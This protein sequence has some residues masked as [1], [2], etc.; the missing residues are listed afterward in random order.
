MNVHGYELIGDWEN[1]NCGKIARATKGGKKYFLKKYQT[2]VA[3]IDNGTLDAKTFAHNQRLFDDF[4]NRRTAVNSRIRTISGAG[5]NIIIPCEEFMDGNQLVEASEFVEGVVAKE[6][7][8]AVLAGL[9]MDTKRLLMLTAAGALSSVHSKGIIHSDLKLPNVLLVKNSM[10]N[11][12]AKL[13]DFDS[14][15]PSDNKP[16]EMIGTP[17]YYSP[18]LGR[19]ITSEDYSEENKRTITEKTDIFSLGLIY[20]FYL[21]GGFPEAVSLT[22]KLQRKKDKGKPIYPYVVLNNGCELRISPE[23]TD[24]TYASLITDMLNIDPTKRPTA[25][26]TLMR[27]KMPGGVTRSSSGGSGSGSGVSTGGRSGVSGSGVITGGITRTPP[28][29]FEA[30]WPEHSVE[31]D[32]AK[33]NSAGFI[34]SKNDTLGGVKGY[35]FYK[36]DGREQFMK[37]E[38]LLLLKYAKKVVGGTSGSTGGSGGGVS[39]PP[40]SRSDAGV[41]TPPPP[42]PRAGGFADPW[43]EHKIV[44]DID[45]IKAKG[46]VSTSQ[47]TMGG[48]NGYEFVR[49]N[50]SAQFIRVETITMLKMAKK[51]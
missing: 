19:Y 48:V 6:D 29:G 7:M 28:T 34:S 5:G 12:V 10:G 43:P 21:T 41:S 24:P 32:T 25:S 44:F 16:D 20:H 14:S 26:E 11:Y 4:F 1:S 46:Y 13:V 50:G 36:A 15:Y 42:P 39:T 37:V 31:F 49:S 8:P 38:T 2:L 27:L 40:P 45:A 51:I 30:P 23:I 9:S 22:E 35:K 3:P 33:L 47:K 18:E 17:D